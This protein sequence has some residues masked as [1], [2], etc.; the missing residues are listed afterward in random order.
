MLEKAVV[1]LSQVTDK[2]AMDSES[3]VNAMEMKL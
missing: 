2:Y 3:Q 1:F